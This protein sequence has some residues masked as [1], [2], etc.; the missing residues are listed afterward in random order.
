MSNR[1][2]IENLQKYL[3]YI[4]NTGGVTTEQFD[5]D[6]EPIGAI[7]REDLFKAGLAQ[8]DCGMLVRIV[9]P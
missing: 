6:W 8:N 3:E 4:D 5:E 2:S 1:Q 9:Q 7:V